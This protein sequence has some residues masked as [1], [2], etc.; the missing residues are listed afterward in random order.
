MIIWINGAF[1]SGKTTAACELARRVPG[2][3]VFDPENI[4]YFFRR[5]LPPELTKPD[6]RSFRLWRA[7][8]RDMLRAYAEGFSG[9]IICPMTLTNPAHFDEIIGELRR[10]GTDVRHVILSASRETLLRRLNKR[11]ARGDTFAKSQIDVCLQAFAADVTEGKIETDAL[12]DSEVAERI[13]EVCGIP[14]PPDRRSGLRRRLDRAAAQ[15]R[16]IRTIFKP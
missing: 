10:G 8:N 14:L 9:V 3:R 2:A 13:G 15:I 4:G 16:V 5:N 7:F 12:G 6:F 1:G 11:L